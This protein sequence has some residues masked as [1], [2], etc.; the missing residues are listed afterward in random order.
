MKN[1]VEPLVTISLSDY[2]E[3]LSN[4]NLL[5]KIEAAEVIIIFLYIYIISVYSN[6]I[7]DRPLTIREINEYLIRNK[8]LINITSS[9]EIKAKII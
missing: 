2:E 7:G 4:I 5:E 1:K 8:V 6:P 9:N 3:L